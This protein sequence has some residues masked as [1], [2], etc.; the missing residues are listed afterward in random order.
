MLSVINKARRV[1]QGGVIPDQG[2]LELQLAELLQ[3]QTLAVIN[4]RYRVSQSALDNVIIIPGVHRGWTGQVKNG[5]GHVVS[6]IFMTLLTI[7]TMLV[8]WWRRMED[9]D[10]RGRKWMITRVIPLFGGM[11]LLSLGL[12]S[13]LPVFLIIS[14]PPFHLTPDST[15]S[16]TS[17]WSTL[18]LMGFPVC[19]PWA[20]GSSSMIALVSHRSNSSPILGLPMCDID[21]PLDEYLPVT[22]PSVVIPELH[23]LVF[24]SVEEEKSVYSPLEVCFCLPVHDLSSL[25]SILVRSR[26][27]SYNLTYIVSRI[28]IVRS[29]LDVLPGLLVTCLLRTPL[30]YSSWCRRLTVLVAGSIWAQCGT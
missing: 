26:F 19:E 22:V 3:D 28:E 23:S 30:R 25:L 9:L 13:Y 4:H 6:F 16:L 17:H 1:V 8:G 20:G 5:L 21:S 24:I 15:V 11:A 7:Q 10:G 2:A 14:D 18:P 29:C 27:T 12:L